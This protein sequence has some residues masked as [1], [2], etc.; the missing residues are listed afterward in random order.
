MRV[1]SKV[2]VKGYG[3]WEELLIGAINAINLLKPWCQTLIFGTHPGLNPFVTS[4]IILRHR[5]Y[6]I[7]APSNKFLQD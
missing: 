3:Y 6:I 1:A 4:V 5:F 2:L 7:I